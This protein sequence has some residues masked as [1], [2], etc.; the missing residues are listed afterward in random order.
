LESWVNEPVQSVDLTNCDREPI[1]ILGAVQPIGFLIAL[2]SDWMVARASANVET[3]LGKGPEEILGKA[4]SEVFSAGAVHDLRNRTIMLRGPDSVERLFG[5]EVVAGRPPLDLA[6][7]LS[8]GSVVIEGEP[9]SGEQQD[10]TSLVRSMIGRL[11]QCTDLNTFFREGARQVRGLTG[12]DRV[13][14]Y[15]FAPDGSGE[16]VGEACKPGIG[17]FFGLRYP[18]SDIPQQARELY[19]RNLLRVIADVDAEPV[20]IVP[21]L[22]PSGRPLDLSLSMLRAVSPIHIEYLRNMGVGASMSIS[23]IVEDRLWGLFA[24]HHYS[25]RCPSFDRRSVCE[26]FSQMF[27][28]RLEARERREHVAYE[29]RA[30]D[31]SDQLLGAIASNE[32]L[33]QDP[34]WLADILMRAI[35]A[36]GMGIW[37]A[38][39]YAFSGVTPPTEEFRRIIRALN[40]T[41]AGKVFATDHIGSILDGAGAFASTAAGMLAIPISR[42]PRDYVVLFRSELVR[43]VRWGGDPHKPVEY[44][45]NGPRLTPRQSFEEWKEL[46]QGKS[47]P[48]S[49]AELRVAETLRATLIE[50]VLRLA[51][52]ATAERQQASARQEMLIAELNHRVRNILGVIR[53]LIRQSQPA[54]DPLGT[55]AVRDFVRLVDGRIHAL[56]RAHN[57]ITD[58]HWGP[59]PM[60]AL[61]DAETAAIVGDKERLVSEGKPLLLKPQAY[62]TLALLLHELV[63]NS[64][65]YGSLSVPDGR[66]RLAWHLDAKGDLQLEWSESGGPPVTPPKRKGFGTTIIERS[67]PYD[68][69]G[70]AEIAYD[71]AGIRAKFCIPARHVVEPRPGQARP[72]RFRR[73]APDHP[74]ALPGQILKDQTVLLV[75]DSLIIA[76][77]A[78]DI[79]YRLGAE[80]VVTAA[81][82]EAALDAIEN[83]RPDLAL[84]DINLGDRNSFPI[85]HRLNDLGIPLFF[86]TGYGEQAQLPMEHRSRIVVQ[87]PYTLEIVARAVH[88][89][90][91]DPAPADGTGT[92][93]SVTTG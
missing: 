25:P 28:M 33:L 12:F 21:Q 30:R 82:I 61:I 68:L 8:G 3:W 84:L 46:V 63:T 41:A 2:T 57:Q 80:S 66:T 58:D 13:M 5:V 56:A 27:S 87:K 78:E 50:V 81:T 53:G 72:V 92:A 16:V 37:I 44:G 71:P 20:P 6:L 23:I 70:T 18:A 48:F 83:A 26:L 15:R 49:P 40:G 47:Q 77:D 22:D 74:Q 54:N 35:P 64:T 24:C 14:V 62:S 85:A 93:R 43:A 7:H 73:S 79:L 39:S 91:G 42:S 59:A 36:D 17:T 86:A 88:E 75:E 38:G 4:L 11:D 60:Q 52:E 65:K 10:S 69:G 1:H 89:L 51:D 29:R 19:R 90:I 32:T 9:S 76:L 34:E 45:P 31:I 55:P 67:I